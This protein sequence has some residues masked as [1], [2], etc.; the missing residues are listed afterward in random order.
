VHVGIGELPR[1]HLRQIKMV[2]NLILIGL[3]CLGG[4]EHNAVTIEGDHFYIRQDTIRDV[5][6][7]G[8]GYYHKG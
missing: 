8:L 1:R 6:I 4:V 7:G 2:Q 5:F 3:V